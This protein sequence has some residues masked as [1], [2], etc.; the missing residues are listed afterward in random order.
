LKVGSSVAVTSLSRKAP[1]WKAVEVAEVVVDAVK[2]AP[3]PD[4]V[5]APDVV[6]PGPRICTSKRELNK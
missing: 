3:E 2:S 1:G 5:A 4:A 6:T